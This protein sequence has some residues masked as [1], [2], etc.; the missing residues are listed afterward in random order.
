MRAVDEELREPVRRVGVIAAV[1]VVAAVAVGG[2]FLFRGT[3]T[4][5]QG[6]RIAAEA[7]LD[8]LR[9]GNIGGAYDQLCNETRERVER[10]DFVAGIGGRPAVR[11]YTIDGL[12]VAGDR[13]ATV[14][15]TLTD[16]GGNPTAY[17]LRVTVDRGIWRVCGNPLD[18]NG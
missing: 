11:G 9:A 12:A 4:P 6:A 7:F 18:T 5:E 1:F 8:R 15:A 16:P 2:F 17:E 10:D 3:R 14:T 13:D